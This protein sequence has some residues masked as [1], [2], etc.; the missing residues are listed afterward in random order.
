LQKLEIPGLVDRQTGKIICEDNKN[1]GMLYFLYGGKLGGI[2]LF[3]IFK[4]HWFSRLV[5]FYLSMAFSRRH[6]VSVAAKLQID[7][8]EAEKGVDQFSSFNDFFVRKLKKNARPVDGD[9][10]NL[11]LPADGRVQVLESATGNFRIKGYEFSLAEFLGNRQ[12]AERY[13]K[14]PMVIVRLCPADY[15]RFHFPCA[16]VPSAAAT[17]KGDLYS[18]HPIAMA[19]K[20]N[21]GA[22]NER[23]L[24]IL[25]TADFG[26]VLYVEIGATVVGKIVQ[27]YQSYKEVEKGEEKGLFLLGGSTVVLLFEPGFI[28]LDQDLVENTLKGLET[29][30]LM[31][32][33]FARRQEK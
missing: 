16:G 19:G 26:K 8:L 10:N 5:G 32:V 17:I 13:E 30:C 9:K 7:L 33:R 12:L 11:V 31:G 29:R 27:T 4:K 24:T 25:E 28:K 21:I 20:R 3:L 6:I 2:L 18:V 23:Q 1:E 15:H 22:L 14:G